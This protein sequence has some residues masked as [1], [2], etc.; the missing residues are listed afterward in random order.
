MTSRALGFFQELGR[1]PRPAK[2]MIVVGGDVAL[3]LIAVALAYWLRLSDWTVPFGMR[4]SSYVAAPLLAIPIFAATGQYRAIFRF[5]GGATFASLMRA[6]LIYGALYAAIYTVITVPDVPRTVGII[7]PLLFI[8]FVGAARSFIQPLIMG[9]A[10]K[11]RGHRKALIFGAGSAGQ[12]IQAALE[13]THEMEVVGFVDDDPSLQ[14]GLLDGKVIFPPHNL[15]EIIERTG[16][17]DFILAIPSAPASRR[18]AIIEELAGLHVKIRSLPGFVDIA[19]GKIEI[20]QLREPEIEDLLGRDA[21]KP[22]PELIQ[23]DTAG[24]TVLVSGAGGSIGSEL[25]RQIIRQGPKCVILLEISEFNLY[26][27]HSELLRDL[28]EKTEIVAVLGSILERR[29]LETVFTTY[30]PDTVYHAAAYKHVPI[31]EQNICSGVLNNVIGTLRLV[32][33]AEQYGTA[34]FVLISTDKAVRPTNVMGASKRFAEQILQAKAQS[35]CQTKLTMVRFGNVLGSSGSVVPLFRRQIRDGGPVTLTHAEITRYFMLIPEASQL[36]IQAGAM[37]G[38]GEVFVLNMGQPIRIIDLARR[39]IE[40]SG[41]TERTADNPEGDI[42]IR[43]VGLRPGEK[44]YE[45]LLIGDNPTQTDHQLIMA[46]RESYIPWTKL[47]G[48]LQSLEQYIAR[49]DSKAVIDLLMRVV[50][51]FQP[52]PEHILYPLDTSSSRGD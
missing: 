47:E 26:N 27:I 7:Q 16:A 30:R 23:R 38:V 50:P 43:E 10:G 9:A 33:A 36:V 32:Q 29:L 34:K 12:Q 17:T 37:G 42:E 44:L 1:L 35:G 45:E 22:Q 8:F 24:K 11:Q 46:A 21:V 6:G 51:E 4:W 52:D 2:R 14:K 19:S 25:C 20:S 48:E 41:L 39:M 31:V 3:C 28:R 5:A 18:A 40:L 49:G 15:G 13:R